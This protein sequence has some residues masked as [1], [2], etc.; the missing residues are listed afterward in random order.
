MKLKF[1]SSF[2][3]KDKMN[4]KAALQAYHSEL[5]NIIVNGEGGI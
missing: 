1:L 4:I 2:Q 3:R 5:K